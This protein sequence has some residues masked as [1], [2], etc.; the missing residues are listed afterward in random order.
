MQLR[1]VSTILAIDV[2]ILR[3]ILLNNPVAG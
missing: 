2:N 3:D 1:G